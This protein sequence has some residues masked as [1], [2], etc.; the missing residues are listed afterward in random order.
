MHCISLGIFPLI[1]TPLCAWAVE[2]LLFTIFPPIVC[3]AWI[4][5]PVP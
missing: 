3:Q 1:L 4:W 5:K 2:Q